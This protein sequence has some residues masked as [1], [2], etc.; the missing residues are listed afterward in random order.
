MFIDDF[1]DVVH[2]TGSN[3]LSLLG[4]SK[5]AFCNLLRVIVIVILLI[6]ICM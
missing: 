5:R 2:L 4:D 1:V 3:V 6:K